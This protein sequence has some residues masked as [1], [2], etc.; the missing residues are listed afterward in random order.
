MRIISSLKLLCTLNIISNSCTFVIFFIFAE[1]NECA[2]GNHTCDI[3]AICTNIRGSF[4]CKCDFGYTGD[5][6]NCRG[7]AVRLR[8][9][10]KCSAIFFEM[11]HVMWMYLSRN[12]IG[13]L[14]VWKVFLLFSSIHQL[15]ISWYFLCAVKI[16]AYSCNFSA[17]LY[18][19]VILCTALVF[20]GEQR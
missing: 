3:S 1:H 16:I 18:R 6:H 12:L 17:G 15:C 10:G 11:H 2:S 20:T 19:H 8:I 4:T 13:H 14:D 5:G 7:R 9:Y